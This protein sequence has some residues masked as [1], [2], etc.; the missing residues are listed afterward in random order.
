MNVLLIS[1]AVLATA[2]RVD[3][4]VVYPDRAQVTR[5]LSLECGP[6]A[7]A[8]FEGIPPSADV[9]TFRARS[10][11]GEVT[12]LRSERHSRERAYSKE[13]DALEEQLHAVAVEIA[14]HQHAL[15]RI[16]QRLRTVRQLDDVAI[17][18][19]D[20]ELATPKPNTR[21][22]TDAFDVSL[23]TALKA[24]AHRVQEE[25]TMRELRRRQHDLEQRRSDRQA[26]AARADITAEVVVRCASGQTRVELTYVVGGASWEPVYEARAD[27][28][29]KQVELSTFATVRQS[30]GEDWSGAKIALSTALPLDNATPPEIHPLK[31]SAEKNEQDKK[32]IVRRDEY[33]EHA[34]A[35]EDAPQGQPVSGA[36]AAAS[37]GLS[38]QLK[39]PGTSDVPSN[40]KPVRLFVARSTLKAGF[41]LRTVPKLM[42]FVFKVA[43]LTNSAPFPLLPGLLDAYG[44][45]GFIARYELER[46]AQGGAFHLT[47]GVD[48]RIRVKRTVLEEVQRDAGLF[49]SL[50]RYR[51]GYRFELA[52]YSGSAAR[53]VLAEH[54]PVSELDD[55]KVEIDPKTSGGYALDA[56]DGIASWKVDL[57]PGQQ[58]TLEL[59][60]HVDVPSSYE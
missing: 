12:G 5:A 13:L 52:N 53:L 22:W 14:T 35:G 8:L 6:R 15:E 37:Q 34:E 31:V 43:D 57:K 48:E 29:A 17:A 59:A 50:K 38:V 23:S 11:A 49:G 20:R 42:P 46:V 36:M 56:R 32:V 40:G 47:F 27:E 44:S 25:A 33:Q 21:A 41:A 26:S 51:Y 18:L 7:L 45:S 4:I 60:F 19:I 16:D 24:N 55:V 10:S 1:I 9:S 54:V 28:G 58:Q 30:T 2:S 39:V 3:S